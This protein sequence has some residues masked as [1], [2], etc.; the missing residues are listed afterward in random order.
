MKTDLDIQKEITLKKIVEVGK[1]LDL[2]EDD[3]DLYGKYKAKINKEV[4]DRINHDGSVIL[5][6][7][8]TPTK[9]GEGKTT[10]SIGL[11]QA[12]RKIGKR[13][14][15]ALREPSLGPVMGLKGGATG[16]GYSQVLPMDEINFH[17]TG[18]MHA[19]TSANNLVSATIDNEI[20]FNSKL[21]IDPERVVFRRCMDVNDRSLRM[22]KIGQGSKFNGVERDDEF[23]ITV[24]SEMMA[25]LCLSKNF[26]D[27]ENRLNSI[28]VAYN[29]DGEQVF[30][31]DLNITGAL[32]LLLKDAFKPNLVQTTENGPA[33]IHGGPFANIAHGCNSIQATMFAKHLADYVVTEAGF[34]ADLGL[35]K[36]LDIKARVSNIH[37]KCVVIV[38]TIRALK[39]HG[40]VDKENLKE[41]NVKAMLDGINNLERHI[42]TIKT[43]NL[44][45]VVAINRFYS[46]T[47]NEVKALENYLDNKGYTYS[48]ANIHTEGGNGGIDLAEKV[49]NIVDN[50]KE[51]TLKYLYE[52]TDEIETK[53]LKVAKKAYG[54]ENIEISLKAQN[55]IDEYKRLGYNNLLI[56]MAKTQNSVTDDSN[57]LNAPTGFTI[58]VKDVSLS[59]GAGFIVVYTGKI[60][61]MP[62]LPEDPQAKHMGLD[63]NLEPY[64]IM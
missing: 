61:T 23:R 2:T 17:F 16:G 27:L 13:V 50:N 47:D 53:I 54:A 63:D 5:V 8:I 20:Y 12:L 49:A 18:D 57:V 48:L 37:P 10:V 43:F 56:C 45:F 6:T 58:H 26:K 41:E 55:K 36:F 19:L 7:A 1:E 14:C 44:P 3:L 42:N 11:A 9:A 59:L 51:D 46:D 24:A 64:G 38:A 35:E 21:N 62:G 60:I 32:L 28:L 4:L 31:K 25:V 29:K 22:V 15:L 33:I 30:L 52:E 39:M 34:G 40:G